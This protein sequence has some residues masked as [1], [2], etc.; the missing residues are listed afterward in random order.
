MNET[1]NPCDDFY[2][3]VCGSWPRNYPVPEEK[4]KWDLDS[5]IEE[6]IN[7]ILKGRVLM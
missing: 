5:M 2:S 4:F 3:Y 7:T 1:V 6:E